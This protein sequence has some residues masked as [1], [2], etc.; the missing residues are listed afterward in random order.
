IVADVYSDDDWSRLGFVLLRATARVIGPRPDPG[1]DEHARALAAL[2]ARY[3]QYRAMA[4]EARPVIAAD[5]TAVTVWGRLE[6]CL[7]ARRMPP[8]PADVSLACTVSI[9]CSVW[10]PRS[11]S[12][13]CTGR[14]ARHGVWRDRCRRFRGCRRAAVPVRLARGGGP[15]A[16][17]AH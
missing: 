15:R 2:R 17:D 9:A 11:V 7:P 4:L 12:I 8:N 16:G 5:I 3:P 1:A 13:A 6:D 14:H 10:I